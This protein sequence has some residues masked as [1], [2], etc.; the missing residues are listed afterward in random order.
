MNGLCTKLWTLFPVT[1]TFLY[2]VQIFSHKP[3]KE[4]LISQKQLVDSK[5][6]MGL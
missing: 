1:G 3:H 4:A 6:M 5:M 2:F